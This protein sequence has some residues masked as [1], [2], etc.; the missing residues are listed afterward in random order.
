MQKSEFLEK[1]KP[2][3]MTL[4]GERKEFESDLDSMVKEHAIEI[5]QTKLEDKS[6][7]I[8]FNDG[9]D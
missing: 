2:L 9:M 6:D 8:E 4:S 1:W 3:R 7:G 5:S